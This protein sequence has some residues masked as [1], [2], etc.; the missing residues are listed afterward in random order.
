[1]LD[2]QRL[3]RNGPASAFLLAIIFLALSLAHYDPAD[4]P[5]HSTE[6]VRTSPANPCGPVGAALAHVLFTSVGWTSLLVVFGL[7]AIDLLWFARRSVAERVGPA[8]GFAL[9]TAV[10]AALVHKYGRDLDPRPLVGSGG[11]LGALAVA[12]FEGQFG[13][14]GMLLILAA[15]GLVGLSLCA[16]A[17]FVW[18]FQEVVRVLGIKARRK[19]VEAAEPIPAANPAMLMPGNFALVDT[20]TRL[21]PITSRPALSR[22][23]SPDEL[24]PDA[25]ARGLNQPTVTKP[26]VANPSAPIPSAPAGGGYQLPPLELLE[27]LPSFPVHEHEAKINARALLVERTLLDFGYNVRVVQIDTGP[28]ITQFEIELEAGLRVSRIISLADDLAIAM[29]VPSVRIVAPIPGKTTVGIEVPNEL[30]A[31]VKLGEVVTEIHNRNDKLKIPLFLGKDVKGAPLAFDLADMPHLLIA[32]RTGTGKS[33]CLNA[34]I[35]SI[36]MTKRPDEV[37]LILIDPKMVELSQFKKIPHLMHPVVTDMKKAESLL[38]WACD[39]MDER[40]GYL[41]RAGVR[42]IQTYN[43]LGADEIYSRLRPEDDEE[44][45]RIPTYMP[46]IVIIADE[47]ADLMMTAAKEVESHIVRLAQK[48]RAVGMHLIVATQKPTVDVITGLIKGNLPARIAFQVASRGDSRVVLDEMG[49]DKLLGNGDMLFLFPGTS[50]IVRAQGTYV[51]DAEVN[52]VCQYLEQF[53]A[54]YSRELVQMQVS[55]GPGGKERGA[56]LKERDE[57]YEPAIEIIIREGRGSCSLLQRALGIGYGRAARL[58]DFMAEDGIVGEF[59]SGSARE[60][61]YSWDEWEALKNGGEVAAG[62]V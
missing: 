15:A 18:P 47:M 10:T 2:R 42:N 50:H 7:A 3:T 30:R 38:S 8:A 57:L 55:G 45:A 37:K 16:E 11:Y 43:Q 23:P 25:G 14:L 59:K 35:L 58:I 9:L 56:A 20:T 53:P 28:V 6:P 31:M 1:M 40:Y 51:S 32:G 19:P 46:Y 60:V 49:A 22:P 41:A 24:I 61:L 21:A 39:K 29:A 48:A 44:M 54:E 27:P 52:R 13:L 12:F 33:V 62:S 26:A 4:P 5:G 34:M 36:L 17:L